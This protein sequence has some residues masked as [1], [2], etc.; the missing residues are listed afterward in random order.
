MAQIQRELHKN[1]S[2]A[3]RRANIDIHNLYDEAAEKWARD[4]AKFRDDL[5]SR[6]FVVQ[7][8][9]ELGTN[10]DIL[11]CGCGDGNLSRLVSPFAK[12][13]IGIDLSSRM[14]EEA[15]RRSGE[16]N[17]VSYV[18]GNLLNIGEVLHPQSIDLCLA[19]FA[20]CCMKNIGQLRRTLKQIHDILRP[21]GFALIQIPHPLESLYQEPSEW[22]IDVDRIENYYERGQLVRRNLRTVNADWV[23]VARYHFP[24]SDYF[25]SIISA[26]LT[27]KSFFEPK[28]SADLVRDYPTLER[29]ARLPSSVIFFT[30]RN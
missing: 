23:L 4:E 25:E 10:K 8:A 14:L 27:I 17:N 22:F 16:Y 13:V 15:Q 3:S 5:I 30:Q 6:P 1:H 26:G 18:R 19:I 24:L 11:D 28:A 21:G 9:R 2:L 7:F 12:N 20:L 29:E